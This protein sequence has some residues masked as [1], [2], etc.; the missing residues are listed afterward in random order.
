MSRL[1]SLVFFLFFFV[2]TYSQSEIYELRVY[3]LEFSKP[4]NVLHDYFQKA[5]IPALNRQGINNVGAFEEL[6]EAMPKKIY[7]L[8]SYPNMQA[9]QEAAD[10]LSND[11][12]FKSDAS[13]YMTAPSDQIPFKRIESSFIRSAKGFPNLVKP[14]D[15]S[16][17]FELRIYE[18]YNEDALRRKV[19]MFNDS[20]FDIFNDVGHHMVFFGANISGD[21]MPCLTYLIASKDMAENKEAWS[22]FGPHP[23]WQRIVKLEEYANAM[24]SITRVFLKPLDYSQL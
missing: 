18:S 9:H 1:I 3:E 19:K 23:E 4:A 15:D 13:S 21:Q 12:Q 17:V 8:I 22:K 7:L 10:Q 24:N 2:S 5:L 20:E 6:G 14:A 16:E 11:A